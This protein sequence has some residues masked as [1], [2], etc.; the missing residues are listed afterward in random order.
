MARV[1]DA[2][3][4]TAVLIVGH[5]WSVARYLEFASKGCPV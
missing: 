5:K 4:R 3:S 2:K 1:G